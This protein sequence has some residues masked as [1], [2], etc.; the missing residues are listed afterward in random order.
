MDL[1]PLYVAATAFGGSLILVSLFFGGA[2]KDFDKDFEI[3][4]DADVDVDVDAEADFDAELEADA[5]FD[6]DA[7]A[8]ADLD[9]DLGGALAEGAAQGSDA[10][11]LPFLSLRFWTFGLA[12]FGLTGVLAS[13]LSVGAIPT[14]VSALLAGGSLGTGAAWFFQRIKSDTVSGETGFQRYTGEEARVLLTIRPGGTGKIVVQTLAGRIEMLAQTRDA[15]PIERGQTVL[16][17]NVR[18]GIADVSRLHPTRGGRSR[19]E[20]AHDARTTAARTKQTV[21][22]E[23]NKS[24]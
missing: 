17:A 7:E 11:W 9:K 18:G 4:A 23:R 6:A 21:D 2:D 15:N 20:A 22:P 19:S 3:E 12:S 14:L 24:G 1:F 13:V 10:I 5:D 16:I 8:E